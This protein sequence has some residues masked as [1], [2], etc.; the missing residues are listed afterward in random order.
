MKCKCF[1]VTQQVD[2]IQIRKASSSRGGFTAKEMED[3]CIAPRRDETENETTYWVEVETLEDVN[4]L[5]KY[6]EADIIVRNNLLLIH[7]DYIE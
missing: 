3:C 4:A 2:A 5:R 1:E 6:F 7:D